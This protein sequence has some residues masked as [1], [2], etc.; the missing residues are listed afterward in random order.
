MIYCTVDGQFKRLAL[1]P[2]PKDVPAS[3]L[4]PHYPIGKNLA[5]LGHTVGAFVHEAAKCQMQGLLCNIRLVL[6]SFVTSHVV[7]VSNLN[8]LVPYG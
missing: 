1:S 7:L 6:R 8:Y 3:A 5:R 2:P 4:S